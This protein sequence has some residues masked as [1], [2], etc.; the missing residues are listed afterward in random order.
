MYEIHDCY[1]MPQAGCDIITCDF[2]WEVEEYFEVD[3]AME[4]LRMGYASIVSAD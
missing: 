2:W 1:G 3:A 4:R